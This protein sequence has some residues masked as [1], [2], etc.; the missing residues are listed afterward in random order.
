MGVWR[1]KSGVS[2][3]TFPTKQFETYPSMF[4]RLKTYDPNAV[5]ASCINWKEL[6]TEILKP[7]DFPFTHE[8]N[9]AAV[10]DSACKLLIEQER[11][12]ILFIHLD[13]VD[14]AGHT[15]DY[16][17]TIPEYVASLHKTDER[18][19]LIFE[20]LRTKRKQFAE[21]DWMILVTTDHGGIDYTHE[22]GRPENR[23]NFII[24]HGRDVA[25][26]EIFPSPLIVDVAP[27]VLAHLGVKLASSWHLDG[28]P[29]GL[30][31][32][33]RSHF[34]CLT[35]SQ[36]PLNKYP[37][38]KEELEEGPGPDISESEAKQALSA[39]LSAPATVKE[40]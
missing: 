36:D 18:I 31:L 19:K 23:T 25:P 21:E 8:E 33:D 26:G 20:T 30:K 2:G 4:Q 37:I 22:D 10:T 38:P 14:L 3:N 1:D 5:T 12:D 6:N 15:F 34:M 9:D 24:V 11:L 40:A 28:R 16:G 39:P 27:T 17:P 7:S 13:D 32:T 29:V 35:S